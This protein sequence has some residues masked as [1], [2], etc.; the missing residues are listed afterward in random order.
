MK[1]SK[2]LASATFAVF[3]AGA[4]F[5]TVSGEEANTYVE[6]TEFGTIEYKWTVNDDNTLEIAHFEEEGLSGGNLILDIPNDFGGNLVTSIAP[7][8]FSGSGKYKVISLPENLVSIGESSF[9]EIEAD[10]VNIPD[11]VKNIGEGAFS[12]SKIDDIHLGKGLKTIEKGVFKETESFHINIP[13]SV[14]TIESAAF[15]D[16]DI[17]KLTI[18]KGI[19]KIGDSSFKGLKTTGLTLPNSISSIGDS[20]FKDTKIKEFNFGDNLETIGNHAFQ[21]TKLEEVE[22]PNSLKELG[23][24]SFDGSGLTSLTIGE[25]LKNI[26][27][28]SFSNNYLKEL[29][30]PKNIEE[31]GDYAFQNNEL[32]KVIV[33]NKDITYNNEAFDNQNILDGETEFIDHNSF[34]SNHKFVNF[35]TENPGENI[36]NKKVTVKVNNLDDNSPLEFAWGMEDDAPEDGWESFENGETL[37]SP[38]NIAGEIYLFVRGKNILGNPIDTKYGKLNV[39][40]ISPSSPMIE[41]ET[42]W[43]NENVDV[44]ITNGKDLHSEIDKTE[45]RIDDGE[46]IEY[47]GDLT[48]KNEGEIKIEARTIDKPG[49]ISNKSEIIIKV[50][51]T[52]PELNIDVN[53]SGDGLIIKASDS[54][55]GVKE[56]HLSNGSIVKGE[57]ASIEITKAGEYEFKAI[58]HAGNIATEIV[59]IEID[60]E[61]G[62]ASKSHNSSNENNSNDAHASEIEDLIDGQEGVPVPDTATNYFNLI[63]LG[64]ALSLLGIGLR[65]FTKRKDNI[66]DQ[67]DDIQ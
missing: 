29:I 15:E 25:G 40:A 66:L 4:S 9:S 65:F 47:K 27:I 64:S 49:N 59:E 55:S 63:G 24:F 7:N 11:T 67:T 33:Q 28:N 43:T 54:L 26:P 38:N 52:K 14:N 46:W 39:D 6:E 41:A 61:N 10:E 22:L 21:N 31:I 60:E 53:D 1:K 42:N 16:A 3:M 34:L 5:L 23:E 18:G 2:F 44:L 62:S 37:T 48:I 57:L 20:S 50:D 19:N 35:T 58:D 45:Y 8:V 13:S 17:H 51:K 36:Q 12:N 30:I 32:E 56:I